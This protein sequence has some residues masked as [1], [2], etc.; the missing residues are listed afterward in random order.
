KAAPGGGPFTA[1][2]WSK[3]HPHTVSFGEAA[4]Q[5]FTSAGGNASIEAQFDPIANNNACK[6]VTAE[7]EPNT[8]NY[9]TE[10]NGFTLLGLPT[11]KATITTLGAFPDIAARLW[12]VTPGGKQRLVSR[13][14]YRVAESQ[15][16]TTSTPIPL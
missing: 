11:V 16:N 7:T 2:R 5:T 13:G 8:A 12:D 10:S 1:T 15:E 9:T 4:A 3:L 6:S 14:V